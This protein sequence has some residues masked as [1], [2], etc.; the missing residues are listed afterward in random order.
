MKSFAQWIMEGRSFEYGGS[1]YSSGFGKYTKDGQAIS[2]EEYMK[3]SNAYK[4]KAEPKKD[5]PKKKTNTSKIKKKEGE[6]TSSKKKKE[7]DFAKSHFAKLH[8][9]C[10]T[11]QL[12][13][14]TVYKPVKSLAEC[15]KQ[16]SSFTG[17]KVYLSGI[18]T[19]DVYNG[20]GESVH[21]V[22]SKYPYLGE[23]N[24][25]K[26]IATQSG[27]NKSVE[28][29]VDEYMKSP[30]AKTRIQKDL[31][32]LEK[33]YN[34][35]KIGE[36]LYKQTCYTGM[37]MAEAKKFREQHGIKW[38]DT[39]DEKFAKILKDKFLEMREKKV[40]KDYKES[41]V[42]NEFRAKNAYAFY[43]NSENTWSSWKKWAGIYFC[44][45][46]MKKSQ[47]YY[48]KQVE[49]GYSPKGTDYKAIVTHEIGH[50]MDHMLR[51]KDDEEILNL[52][53]TKDIENEVSKY[54]RTHVKEFIAEAFAEYIHS[55]N[56]RSIAKEVG[57]IIDKKY[58]NYAMA[59]D[60]IGDLVGSGEINPKDV[61][62]YMSQVM[63]AARGGKK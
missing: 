43:L 3:A 19:K 56:P 57:K 59:M 36:N 12:L 22:F 10:K 37:T 33:K 45:S 44:P 16:I 26:Y 47:E 60:V 4:G 13:K 61:D 6:K 42:P 54:A 28:N 39:I 21:K 2:K 49:L 31:D 41:L 24:G 51:L 15:E 11:Y 46:N 32:W 18:T 52:F 30:E 5:Y 17:K 58:E 23:F 34:F 53:K 40:R 35:C 20:I 50:A 38:E 63:D 62:R 7:P 48:N 27:M 9:N 1:K 14:D 25:L 8:T 29:D 55:D